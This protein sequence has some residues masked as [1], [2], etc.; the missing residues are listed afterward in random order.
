MCKVCEVEIDSVRC[1]FECVFEGT[2]TTVLGRSGFVKAWYVLDV[3]IFVTGPS[4]EGILARRLCSGLPSPE[5]L[6]A[7]TGEI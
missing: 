7:S 3:L 5:D 1:R 2:G 6:G 4:S